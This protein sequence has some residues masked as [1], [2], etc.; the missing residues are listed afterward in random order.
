MADR[1]PIPAQLRQLIKKADSAAIKADAVIK[2]AIRDIR[3]ELGIIAKE[4][5]IGASAAE[6][7]KIFS[8][9]RKKMEKL[10]KRLND[11]LKASL[12][13]AGKKAA[14]RA[15]VE[16]G[17]E[18]KYSKRHAD[19]VVALI[20]PAQGANVAAVFTDKMETRVIDSL[21]R[22]V[23]SAFQ[24]NAVAGG[25]L[26]SL[27]RIIGEKWQAAAKQNETFTFTDAAGRRWD[28][29]TYLNMNTRTNAMRVYND[30]LVENIAKASGSDLVRVSR[31]GDPK[32]KG[33]GP[34][35]GIIL[36]VSGETNG[37]PTYDEAKAAGCFHPN[38][39]HTLEAVD[40]TADA[41]EIAR[42]AKHPFTAELIDDPELQASRRRDIDEARYIDA[43]RTQEE[44]RLAV[45]RDYL[46]DTIRTGL[47]VDNAGSIVKSL[48]DGQIE[49]IC[50]GGAVPSFTP[51]KKNEAEVYKRGS[52]GGVVHCKRTA[53]AADILRI[54]GVEG[55]D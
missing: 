46:A 13:Y 36:S 19:E 4:R 23:V 30:L 6:R 25:S 8:A 10:K 3:G 24:E 17:V 5:P 50:R 38:C 43:G 28:T 14:E 16:T 27:S 35:E 53:T 9:I 41:A 18:V 1:S 40:E 12:N 54:M 37:F 21:R 48:T 15:Q 7:E 44:A 49:A 34:W 55:E 52:R 45:S 51:A 42:Q 29:R 2:Q 20:S 39:V 47:L 31:G 26:K 11:L 32:C 22:A 33:C